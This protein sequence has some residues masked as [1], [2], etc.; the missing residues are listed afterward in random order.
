MGD[1]LS[2]MAGQFKQTKLGR[3]NLPLTQNIDMAVVALGKPVWGKNKKNSLT[4]KSH[5]VA[6]GPV[7]L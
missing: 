4:Q 3:K 5:W 6:N 7:K 2:L 1:G